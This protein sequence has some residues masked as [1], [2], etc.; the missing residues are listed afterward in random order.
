MRYGDASG[1][2]SRVEE[3]K[4][5]DEANIPAPQPAEGE[6]ARVPAPYDDAVGPSDPE[7]AAESR[8]EAAHA[9]LGSRP[10]GMSGW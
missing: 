3:K 9:G 2:E 6:E 8:S 10:R 5:G 1:G 7:G 4:D